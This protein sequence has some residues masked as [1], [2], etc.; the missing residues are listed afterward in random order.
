MAGL[1]AYP[2]SNAFPSGKFGIN[3]KRTVAFIFEFFFVGLQLRGQLL[4][5]TGFPFH[6]NEVMRTINQGCKVTTFF[7]LLKPFCGLILNFLSMNLF[8]HLYVNTGD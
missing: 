7:I 6:L 4:Y 8:N 3:R 2:I 1:L 5:F